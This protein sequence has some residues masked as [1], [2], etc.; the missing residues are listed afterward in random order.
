MIITDLRRQS[1]ETKIVQLM[2]RIY[3]RG[4]GDM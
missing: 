3:I 4:K 1:Y 2:Y